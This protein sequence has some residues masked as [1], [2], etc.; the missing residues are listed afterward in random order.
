MY[1]IRSYYGF[2]HTGTTLGQGTYA[3]TAEATDAAGNTS[4]TSA[5]YDITIDTTA[6]GAPVVTSIS[7][8]TAGTSTTD[9]ITSDQ[10]LRITSYNVCYTKLLREVR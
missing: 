7:D 1:A 10:T 8:D 6:P 4:A 2:D 9:G 5:A 3:I